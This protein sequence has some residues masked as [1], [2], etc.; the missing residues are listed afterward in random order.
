MAEFIDNDYITKKLKCELQE[1]TRI[2]ELNIELIEH[3]GSVGMWI[4]RYCEWNN[5]NPPDKNR[6][7]ELI[8]RSREIVQKIYE[9]Y[10]F[11]PSPTESQQRN[12]TTDKSTEPSIFNNKRIWEFR[13][14]MQYE[15][16]R[17]NVLQ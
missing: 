7:L 8:Q 12:K 3:L 1:A 2:K 9:P 15:E 6:L 17:I 16:P 4:L 13:Y 11:I 5:I 10:S 14:K